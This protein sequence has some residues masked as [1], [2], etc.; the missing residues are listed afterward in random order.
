M[1]GVALGTAERHSLCL[2]G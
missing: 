2:Y 1:T